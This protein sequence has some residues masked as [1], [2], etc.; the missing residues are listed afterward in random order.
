MAD[1]SMDARELLAQADDCSPLVVSAA[2][3]P[4]LSAVGAAV[5]ADLELQGDSSDKAPRTRVTVGFAFDRGGFWVLPPRRALP[6]EA[7]G[8]A[9]AGN[10]DPPPVIYESLMS[11]LMNDPASVGIAGSGE[12]DTGLE[13]PA[14]AG[15]AN[16]MHDAMMAALAAVLANETGG[17]DTREKADG[18]T[19]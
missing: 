9:A 7:G 18:D 6:S 2:L 12:G 5:A 4:S 16:A 15:K 14:G 19:W 3:L 10:P 11:L 1:S 13:P 17:V 8:S